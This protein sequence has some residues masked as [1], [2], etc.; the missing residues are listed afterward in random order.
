[1]A[2]R[3]DANERSALGQTCSFFNEVLA[4]EAVWRLIV[5]EN[6]IRSSS[7]TTLSS[8]SSSSLASHAAAQDPE[9]RYR[10]S[11]FHSWEQTCQRK[12]QER[13]GGEDSGEVKVFPAG[14]DE[15]DVDSIEELLLSVQTE[16]KLRV[17]ELPPGVLEEKRTLS[18][19]ERDLYS[20]VS[21]FGKASF[22]DPKVLRFQDLAPYFLGWP[23]FWTPAFLQRNDIS[24]R[25][26]NVYMK[27]GQ[28]QEFVM[29]LREFLEY[30][31]R[32]SDLEPMYLFENEI[33]V[34]IR[35][36]IQA[37]FILCNVVVVGNILCCLF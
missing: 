29:T 6:S 28:T 9:G 16:N 24:Q 30:S 19:T 8:L 36:K 20:T 21:G 4:D 12:H 32:N 27:I 11:F 33:P 31:T 17:L 22:V 18:A 13:N 5:V 2:L 34:E 7:S 10:I 35:Q 37:C 26:F 3:L 25:L 23:E 1:M 14:D 15:G